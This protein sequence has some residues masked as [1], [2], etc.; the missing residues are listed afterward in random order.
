MLRRWVVQMAKE[1]KEPK[2]GKKKWWL[3]LAIL[4]M[5]L[6][7]IISS[8]YIVVDHYLDM[9]H[10]VDPDDESMI[11]PEE[12]TFETDATAATSSTAPGATTGTTA[13]TTRVTIK[14]PTVTFDDSALL[15]IMLVGQDNYEGGSRQR[16][17]SMILVSINTKTK[18]VSVISFLRDLYVS[19]PGGYSNNRLNT[20][21]RFGGFKLLNQTMNVNFGVTIDGNIAV[22]FDSFKE[23]IDKVGGVDI[24]LTAAE[25]TYM[26]YNGGKAGVAHL[27]GGGALIYARIRHLDSDFVRTQRQRNVLMAVLSKIRQLSVGELMDLM[28]AILPSLTTNMSN[29][30]ILSLMT[31][32]A[33]MVSTM[34]V[35]TY[36][37]PANDA[38]RYASIRGMSVLVPNL[39]RIR[40]DLKEEYLPFER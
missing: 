4:L 9:I 32:L 6:A 8:G 34:E 26:G 14:K 18:K 22:N 39:D 35:N 31:Q 40:T 13:S 28:N 25:A 12:E 11:P 20:P 29:S 10:K 36:R 19:I 21:Y 23:V 30:Q 33:P 3:V 7:L 17:D 15:N 27:D 5:V 37:V 16:S 38:Y 1:K 24:H 2:S